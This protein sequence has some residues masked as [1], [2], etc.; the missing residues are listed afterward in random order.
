MGISVDDVKK[1]IQELQ[2]ML[3]RQLDEAKRLNATA[4]GYVDRALD[5]VEKSPYSPL[6][7]GG[8]IVVVLTLGVFIGWNA[9]GL[10]GA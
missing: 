7:V 6:I 4:D 1:Q 3:A 10:F 5:K 2:A 8:A 9:R